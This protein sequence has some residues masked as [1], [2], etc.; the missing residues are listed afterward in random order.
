MKRQRSKASAAKPGTGSGSARL[1]TGS[2]LE[3]DGDLVYLID[4]LYRE[5]AVRQQLGH[6]YQDIKKEIEAIHDQMDTRTRREYFAAS[7][8]LN[9]VAYENEMA[10]RMTQ[11]LAQARKKSTAR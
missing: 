9:Y 4:T 6:S 1:S 5:I 8:F 10:E 3:L 7:V 11:R 2:S